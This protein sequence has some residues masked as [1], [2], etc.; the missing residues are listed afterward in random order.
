MSGPG[1]GPNQLDYD[2]CRGGIRFRGVFVGI[3][4]LRFFVAR[5]LRSPGEL[6]I[7]VDEAIS[8]CL[9]AAAVNINN[10][11]PRLMAI[12]GK[13]QVLQGDIMPMIY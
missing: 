6:Y 9:R 10:F 4:T 5:P 2:L 8:W 13:S 7:A 1:L 11:L 12:T 3:P